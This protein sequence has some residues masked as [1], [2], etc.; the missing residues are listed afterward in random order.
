MTIVRYAIGLAIAAGI[1]Y[2]VYYI[3]NGEG[4]DFIEREIV[5]KI[6]SITGGD[7]EATEEAPA[8]E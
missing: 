6:T 3:A 1:F 2:G 7:S 5:S 8:A 4:D